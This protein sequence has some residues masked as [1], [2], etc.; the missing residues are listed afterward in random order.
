MEIENLYPGSWGSNCYLLTVGS[1]AALVDPSANAYTLMDAVAQ[2]GAILELIL[3][4]HG[5]FDHIVS[6]DT[7]RQYTDAPVMIHEDDAE[8]L[9]DSTK[10]AFYTFFRQERNYRDADRVLT[11][12]EILKLGDEMIRVIHTPGHSAG[13]V[14]YLC[15]ENQF[16]LTGDTLFDEGVGRCDLWK[17]DADQLRNSL[18]KLRDF[19]QNSLIY[20][21]HGAPARLG[22]A[23]DLAAYL[24]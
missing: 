19:P 9:G 17:G 11:D 7:L 23:L 20:P 18:K 21:G 2:K 4:T 16:L 13:S 12:G 1:H 14:C 8:M 3:L 22:I 10:N 6:I 15:N 24:I 5:H